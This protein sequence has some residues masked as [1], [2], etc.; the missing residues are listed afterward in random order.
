MGSK[1]QLERDHIFPYSKLKGIGYGEGN[2]IKYALAQELTNRAILTQVANRTKSNINA[3]DYLSFVKTNFP[4]ALELQCIPQ[5]EDLWKIENYEHFLEERRN[6]LA[7]QMNAFLEKI[8]ETE[9]IVAP[10]SLEELIAE[11]ESDELEFKSTLRW[12]LKEGIMNKKLEEVILKTV[13]AFANSQGGTLLIGV[14]DD[15][16]VLGLEPDYMSLGGVNRDKFELH[17]RNLFNQQFGAGFVSSKVTISFHEVEGKEVCQIDTSTAKEPV[18]VLIK[19]KNG[20]SLEKFYARSGNSS[21]EIPLSEMN[22]YIMERF[23]K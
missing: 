10:V 19:D 16:Q 11:G 14:D 23:R 9:V 7:K 1:Y 21:Q 15:G 20:Q 18:I 13:A 3:A 12:D 6:L 22:S 8:T 17:I 2:R 4:K 5:D